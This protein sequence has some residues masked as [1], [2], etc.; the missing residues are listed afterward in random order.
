M[1]AIESNVVNHYSHGS[2]QSALLDG[3]QAMGKR[4]ETVTLD[5]LAPVDEFHMGGR[6]A[7]EA[8]ADRLALGPSQHLLDIGSGIG[9]ATRFLASRYDCRATGVDLNPE[10]IE[11]AKLLRQWTGL[12]DRVDYQVASATS[13]PF[14]DAWFNAATMLHVGMNIPDKAGVM[15]EVLRVLRPGAVFVVYDVMQVGGGEPRFPVAWAADASTSF[16]VSPGAYRQALS[17][18]GFTV[19]SETRRTELALEVFA[20]M[21]A[22]I[23]AGGPPPLGLHILMGADAP[24]KVE[25][26]IEGLE[27]GCFAPV[28][29]VARRS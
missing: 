16:L 28:E 23:A 27:R 14:A 20:R 13:L 6:A 8:I 7:T 15:A 26:L 4:P 21:R 24:A 5:D 2:L 1:S 10:Y 22:R 25:N 3:L 12:N 18:A 29:L 19:E 11:V 9:G 17:A